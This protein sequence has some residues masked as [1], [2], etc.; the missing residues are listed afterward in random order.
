MLRVQRLTLSNR[1]IDIRLTV[2]GGESVHLLGPNGAGKSSLLLTLA[3]LLQPDAG[4]VSWQGRS[5]D[6]QSPMELAGYRC[7]MEQQQQTQFAVTVRECLAFASPGLTLPEELEAALEI[8]Q[9]WSRPMNQLSGGELR[10]VQIARSLT[11]IWPAVEA[12]EAM[13]LMDE[14][15]QGL[16]FS[17]QHKLCQLLK[18]LTGRG[19]V[20]VISHHQLNLAQMYAT[21][22][23]L[24]KDGKLLAD[25]SPQQTLEPG[26]LQ[27]VFDCQVR[28]L[29]DTE[30]NRLIQTYLA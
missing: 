3:G 23:C 16:D 27:Q 17:H 12:G 28:V 5:L 26:L 22:I 13:I 29:T 21:R 1:L 9:F 2:S 8:R 15:V 14:P 24:L 20:L 25:G 18:K 30:Q 19:N 4:E 11:Q 6:Q 7:L 10:R